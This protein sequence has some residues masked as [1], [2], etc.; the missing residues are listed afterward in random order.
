MTVK[1]TKINDKKDHTLLKVEGKLMAQDAEMLERTFDVIENG[2]L[3][4]IDLS[5]VTFVDSDGAEIMGRLERKSVEMKGADFFIQS[6]IDA[7]RNES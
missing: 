1:I 5:G 6:I 7:Y 2:E 3:V 4:A